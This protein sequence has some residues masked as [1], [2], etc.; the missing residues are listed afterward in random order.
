[1]DSQT[2]ISRNTMTTFSAFELTDPRTIFARDLPGLSDPLGGLVPQWLNDGVPTYVEPSLR[3]SAWGH[4]QLQRLYSQN[5]NS[6]GLNTWGSWMWGGWEGTM[7]EPTEREK[8]ILEKNP[9]D[10][11]KAYD[12]LDPYTQEILSQR[13]YT[14]EAAAKVVKT[15]DNMARWTQKALND[16]EVLS[17]LDE[18]DSSSGYLYSGSM[19]TLSAAGN[20]VFADPLAV[21][22]VAAVPFTGG[23]SL[24]GSLGRTGAVAA[25]LAAG[26]AVGGIQ[27]ASDQYYGVSQDIQ[28]GL[29]DW[30]NVDAMDYVKSASIG[31]GVGL[32]LAGIPGFL[33]WKSSGIKTNGTS[34]IASAVLGHPTHVNS[35]EAATV[36]SQIDMSSETLAYALKQ[37][38]GNEANWAM[39]I[40]DP[41]NVKFGTMVEHVEFVD[42]VVAKILNERPTADELSRML[43]IEGFRVERDLQLAQAQ[44]GARMVVN[45]P[46][47][48]I[49]DTLRQ[50]LRDVPEEFT[51][52]ASENGY[53]R[54]G[55][56]SIQDAADYVA[57]ASKK[58]LLALNKAVSAGQDVKTLVSKGTVKSRRISRMT[59]DLARLQELAEKHRILG[60]AADDLKI[61]EIADGYTTKI[62]ALS[63]KLTEEI[64]GL[65]KIKERPLPDRLNE[66]PGLSRVI[67]DLES[68][69]SNVF[70]GFKRG[71]DGKLRGDKGRLVSERRLQQRA[72]DLSDEAT[73][74]R[75]A[76][77]VPVSKDLAALPV[78]VAPARTRFRTLLEELGELRKRSGVAGVYDAP[79]AA[80]VKRIKTE[81]RKKYSYDPDVPKADLT[82]TR[83][84]APRN[85][86]ATPANPADPVDLD[87]VRKTIRSWGRDN[88][89]WRVHKGL[90]K[91]NDVANW[92]PISVVA[93]LAN[94]ALHQGTGAFRTVFSNHSETLR[95]FAHLLDQSHLV[96]ADAGR[97]AASWRSLYLLKQAT[98]SKFEK[99]VSAVYRHLIDLK[100]GKYSPSEISERVVNA[101][102][103]DVHDI[104]P[105]INAGVVKIRE[106]LEDYGR[107]GRAIGLIPEQDSRYFPSA[108]DIDAIKESSKKFVDDLAETWT[109]RWSTRNELNRH[110]LR[111]IGILE[112]VTDGLAVTKR[113]DELGFGDQFPEITALPDVVRTQYLEQMPKTMRKLAFDARE[114]MMG[115]ESL[116]P[117]QILEPVVRESK[118]GRL[119][120]SMRRMFDDYTVS[121]ARMQNYFE[122]DLDAVLHRYSEGIGAHIDASEHLSKL[123]G[124]NTTYLESLKIAKAEVLEDMRS[125]NADAAMM[126]EINE[127][128]DTLENK[129]NTLMGRRPEGFTDSEYTALL[130]DIGLNAM[131]TTFG[132]FW[133]MASFT[134]EV[135]GNLWRSKRFSDMTAII[136]DVTRLAKDKEFLNNALSDLG[137]ATELHQVRGRYMANAM[138]TP[139]I[140]KGT[141]DKLR[142]PWLNAARTARQDISVLEKAVAV[143]EATAS[144]T[145]TAGGL[146]SST[147]LA[148]ASRSLVLRRFL[149]DSASQMDEAVDLLDKIPNLDAMSPAQ[150]SAVWDD[151]AAKTG[152]GKYDL[153][154]MNRAGLL[155]KKVTASLKTS[156]DDLKK[157]RGRWHDDDLENILRK[158][159]S[160]DSEEITRS[161]SDFLINEVDDHVVNPHRPWLSANDTSHWMSRLAYA[162][163]SYARGFG[164]GIG[165]RAMNQMNIAD[166]LQT[167]LAFT[168]GEALYR[169]LRDVMSGQMSSEEAERRWREEPEKM[170]Y[171]LVS[172]VPFM[173]ALTHYGMAA[174]GGVT[175]LSG[176]S[177]SIDSPVAG[178]VEQLVSKTKK[179]FSAALDEDVDMEANDFVPFLNLA[180]AY[181]AWWFQA[182]LSGFGLNPRT[183]RED[184][185]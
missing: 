175:G 37:A 20:Y 102:R 103:K 148:R 84:D 78:A 91:F 121:H 24:A 4:F 74:L 151:I 31:A 170:L 177:M 17:A 71:K 160:K 93:K 149:A 167:F 184:F 180:P 47:V 49:L 157:A 133:G 59:R 98:R 57:A 152:L 146:S 134:T 179:A 66:T 139:G 12:L 145:I 178:T 18:I 159:G 161:V 122:K 168:L 114:R 1:M 182:G 19:K 104:D 106:Y 42:S 52:L 156:A 55:F 113:G 58:E 27:G 130:S 132:G 13:G 183:M 135:L 129:Y 118:S 89:Q 176:R 100:K 92:K 143:S 158:N 126:K 48:F 50:R 38:Y 117:D 72:A 85:Q 33:I 73:A 34:A 51:A 30:D 22:S 3:T 128:F 53:Q 142:A 171:R 35:V 15:P 16:V 45:N 11:N 150:R 155:T 77:S 28:A 109:E 75:R 21:A 124:R 123:L 70:D 112:E 60:V 2:S 81:L 68:T 185:K 138:E 14:R 144:T 136:A 83:L 46:R 162:L 94:R 54:F 8:L 110:V 87:P 107:R 119:I 80:R 172:G 116:L 6:T 10:V 181:G 169:T 125:V 41:N 44:R 137:Y 101:I 5:V 95:R 9:F 165:Y 108:H 164:A 76:Q 39:G 69:A 153:L 61:K 86:P 23:I 120:H 174:V 7:D 63:D 105:D 36:L 140:S 65:K 111:D 32:A 99:R 173:G 115:R 56:S 96:E 29:Y 64:A 67:D 166:A 97:K 79:S 131:R 25:T 88:L 147:G 43:D 82:S 141:W 90:N 40:L 127:A 154:Q 26:A 62:A 163:T